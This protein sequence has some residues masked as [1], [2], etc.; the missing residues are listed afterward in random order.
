MK[1]LQTLTKMENGHH[2]NTLV[3]H[4]H[5]KSHYD[6]MARRLKNRERQRRYRSRKRLEADVKSAD[7]GN[8][9]TSLQSHKSGVV[10]KPKSRVRHHRDWKKD[11]R[12]AHIL[13]EPIVASIETPASALSLA[14]EPAA[15]DMHDQVKAPFLEGAVHLERPV[16][17]SGYE[18][19]DSTHG[20]RHWKAAARNK[21]D[22]S[23]QELLHC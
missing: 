2:V 15:H 16:S 23:L 13:K 6:I 17:A 1:V 19:N 12:Q 10:G 22:C 3:K 8:Q 7:L 14:S 21:V 18:A 20:R 5:S 11:A 4:G 9:S